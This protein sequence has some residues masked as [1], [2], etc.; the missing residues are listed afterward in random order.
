MTVLAEEAAPPPW[1]GAGA[2]AAAPLPYEARNDLL[3]ALAGGNAA[4]VRHQ[5]ERVAAQVLAARPPAGELL[6]FAAELVAMAEGAV[7]RQELRSGAGGD[8]SRRRTELLVS[9]SAAVSAQA[10][11]AWL[12]QTLEE[13]LCHP[14]AGSAGQSSANPFIR[15]ARQFMQENYSRNISTADIAGH[16]KLN[17]SYLSELYSRETGETLSEALARIRMEAAMELLKE[18]KLKVYE[19]AEAA[20]YSDSKIFIKAFKRMTGQTP[21]KFQ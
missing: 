8:Y 9:A 20:G 18:G 21:K 10:L 2:A 7:R 17:R 16:V 4:G 1:P 5:L 12:G 13:L 14:G 11:F 3:R 6:A 19:V 15:M